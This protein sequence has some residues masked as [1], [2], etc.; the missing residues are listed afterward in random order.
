MA[1]AFCSVDIVYESVGGEM[2][3]IAIK[4]LARFGKLIVVGLISQ[5]ADQSAFTR[6]LSL[7]FSR[8]VKSNRISFCSCWGA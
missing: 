4:H 2:F 8:L 1:L 3:D 6:S 7:Y 5:Y